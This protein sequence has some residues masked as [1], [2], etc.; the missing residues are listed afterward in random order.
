MSEK[1]SL[2]LTILTKD[3]SNNSKNVEAKETNIIHK[4]IL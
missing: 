3:D 2:F 1:L 4:N